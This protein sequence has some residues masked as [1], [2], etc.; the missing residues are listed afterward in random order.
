MARMDWDRARR[1]ALVTRSTDYSERM[2]AAESAFEESDDSARRPGKQKALSTA[3]QKRHQANVER[4][5]L[6]AAEARRRGIKVKR[7][8]RMI[9]RGEVS[10]PGLPQP[11][12]QVIVSSGRRASRPST[13][14]MARG[15]A[16]RSSRPE[17]PS[18]PTKGATKRKGKGSTNRQTGKRK[19][20]APP[21]ERPVPVCG[22]CGVPISANGRCICS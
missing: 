18:H 15:S 21:P 9:E 10:V 13:T 19:G 7:L 16:K 5:R 22:A 1:D 2:D 8:R 17:K 3:E 6:L 12:G 14:T 11:S 20:L 4:E